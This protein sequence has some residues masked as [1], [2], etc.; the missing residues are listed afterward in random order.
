MSELW[1]KKLQEEFESFTV[2]E[3][4]GLWEGISEAMGKEERRK[5]ILPIWWWSGGIAA[6]AAAVAALFI[7]FRGPASTLS[8][9]SG[10]QIALVDTP[11][12]TIPDDSITGTSSSSSSDT[13]DPNVFVP[14][15]VPSSVPS[16]PVQDTSGTP[17]TEVPGVDE[18]VVAEVPAEAEQA[19][20]TPS[21]STGVSSEP[22]VIDFGYFND[23]PA[24][25]KRSRKRGITIGLYS[26]GVN[27]ARTE[28]YGY[29][30]V[31]SQRVITRAAA[32]ATGSEDMGMFIRMMAANKPSTFQAQHDVP[33]RLGASLSA[34]LTPVLSLST[35]INHTWLN[36]TF[37]EESGASSTNISQSLKYI[38][39]P[40]QLGVRIPR[41][42][43]FNLYVS[44]GPM[45]EYCYAS[46]AVSTSWFGSTK[47]PE[48]YSNP[49][50][51]S[52][53]WSAGLNA[54]AEF[55]PWKHLGLYF[56]PG[57][58]YHFVRESSPESAYTAK[59]L[60]YSFSFGLRFHIND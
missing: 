49:G 46:D 2:P 58:E 13:F 30:L 59:P 48:E 47:A 19:L 52:W 39:V 14:S 33:A 21:G 60:N 20:D 40:L 1:K 10:D 57:V 5:R 36:S 4:E 32:P 18:T 43:K 37:T 25:T 51:G 23:E 27:T 6:A 24:G 15:S 35:G 53:I 38:G 34:Q 28:S 55:R 12:V 8:S 42:R 26:G 45:L 17:E 29:G 50:K 54:G 41:L 31:Q 22:A 16:Q 7:V 44:A 56:E 11:T 9:G 3:P